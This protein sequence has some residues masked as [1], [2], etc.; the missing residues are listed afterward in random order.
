MYSY[1]FIIRRRNVAISRDDDDD[2]AFILKQICDKR[3]SECS[4]C[5]NDMVK[6]KRINCYHCRNDICLNC[7]QQIFDTTAYWCPFC[8][9]HYIYPQLAKPGNIELDTTY[10]DFHIKRMM[11]QCKSYITD[12]HGKLKPLTLLMGLPAETCAAFYQLGARIAEF[13]EDHYRNMGNV[14]IKKYKAQLVR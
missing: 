1:T 14:T 13:D 2:L 11:I 7:A 12:N 5:Y 3:Q 10:L 9:H 4:I 6:N 8:S